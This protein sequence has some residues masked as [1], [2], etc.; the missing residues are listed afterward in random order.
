MHVK[1]G[2]G[3]ATP[4]EGSKEL[5]NKQHPENFYISRE[6]HRLCFISAKKHLSKKLSMQ[7]LDIYAEDI[8]LALKEISKI[9]GRVDIEEIL[10]IV[11]KE[12]CI[13]K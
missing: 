2:V 9:Y 11:F 13:G 12:F 1:F 6:R 7:Q 3:R 8:R 10:D 5:I 4:E